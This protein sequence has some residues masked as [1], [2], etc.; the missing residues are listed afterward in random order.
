ML[1]KAGTGLTVIIPAPFST[2]ELRSNKI[3]EGIN[4]QNEMLLSLGNAINYING[5]LFKS[6]LLIITKEFRLCHPVNV[7]GRVLVSG[8]L[9]VLL[10]D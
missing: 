8:L 9:L 10:T 1:Y 2:N 5:R 7:T 3:N 4:N 6:Y